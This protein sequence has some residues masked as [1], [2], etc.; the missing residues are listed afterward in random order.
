MFEDQSIA[1]DV[2]NQIPISP[3]GTMAEVASAVVFHALDGADLVT[4]HHFLMDGG[5]TVW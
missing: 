2:P 3:L 4:G 1:D 5:W